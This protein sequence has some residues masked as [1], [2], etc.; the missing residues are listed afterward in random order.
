M[1]AIESGLADVVVSY[2][3]HQP[4]R[5]SAAA[6]T[7]IHAEDPAKA[8]FEMPF[9]Y[10]GQPV[11]FAV[12]GRATGHEYG[13]TREQLGAVAVAARAH[14]QRTPNALR[15]EPLDHRR[16]PRRAASSP[17]RCASS[18]AASSTTAASPS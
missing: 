12:R 1:L 16:L 18:T 2:Y 15:R 14:A 9:G 5:S 11:Y 6:P 4:Q 7:P 17:T 13:L 10:Y 3:G 8:A